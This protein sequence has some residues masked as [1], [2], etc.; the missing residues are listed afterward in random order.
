MFHKRNILNAAKKIIPEYF[1][2]NIHR[3]H[4]IERST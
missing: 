1:S 4:K 2:K 3:K